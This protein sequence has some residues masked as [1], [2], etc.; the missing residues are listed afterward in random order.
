MA[1]ENYMLS[2]KITNS[3]KFVTMPLTAQLL[4]YK[5]NEHSDSEGFV[6]NPYSI[7]KA[8]GCTPTDLKTLTDNKFVITYDDQVFVIK[9]YHINNWTRFSR[10]KNGTN[11]ELRNRLF[12][13]ENMAY[14]TNVYENGF[15]IR[16]PLFAY[17]GKK[18]K[19]DLFSA[20]LSEL[21]GN[22]LLTEINDK[23]IKIIS[24][25]DD[26]IKINN[27]LSIINSQLLIFN[28]LIVNIQLPTHARQQNAAKCGEEYEEVD[29]N[30]GLG[31]NNFEF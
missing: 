28:N 22:E 16:Y 14:T 4:Y 17:L 5:L 13:S 21:K 24:N 6:Y 25:N 31:D 23:A 9:H 29:I 1:K 12:I 8:S 20:I 19:K 7:L 10:I 15:V 2:S 26:N 18:V 30:L 27:Q 3:D 11:S